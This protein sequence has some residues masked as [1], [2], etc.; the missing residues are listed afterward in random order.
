V[1]LKISGGMRGAESFS[2]D[3][4]QTI[5]GVIELTKA[6]A[7]AILA[8]TSSLRPANAHDLHYGIEVDGSSLSDLIDAVR[9]ALRKP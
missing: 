7:E 1:I 3:A 8:R 5:H 2:I 9:E 6:Q 4:S